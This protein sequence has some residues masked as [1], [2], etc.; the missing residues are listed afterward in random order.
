MMNSTTGSSP[1][2]RVSRRRSRIALALTAGWAL[3]LTPAP[4]ASARLDIGKDIEKGLG[5]VVAA[6]IEST[7]GVVDDP[8]LT[9]W[10]N[11]LGQHL[12]AVSGRTD[13]KYS[14][15]VLDSDE[16]NAT[17]APGGYIFVDRG[18][19]RFIQS[20]D[21]L[22]AVM[23][24]EVGHVAGR[25]AM[26]QLN[27]Q[28]LGTLALLGFQAVH[29]ETLKTVGG[30]AG[31]LAMLKYTRDQENDADRRGLRNATATGYD[32]SAMLTFFQRLETTEKEKPSKLEVYFLTHPPTAERIRRISHEPGAADTAANE[33]AIGDGCAQRSLFRSAVAAYRRSLKADPGNSAVKQRLADAFLQ[34][35]QP[36]QI[37]RLSP[38]DRDARLKQLAEFGDDLASAHQT[39]DADLKKLTDSQKDFDSELE[40]AARSL[41]TVSNVVN[42][43]D[44]LRFREFISMAGSFDQATR[45]GG[46]LRAA[47]DSAEETFRELE[48]LRASLHHAVESGDGSAALQV[49]GLTM[50]SQTML[51]DLAEGLKSARSESHGAREAAKSLHTAA[52]SLLATYRSPLSLTGGQYNILDLQVS[53]AQDSLKDTVAS[54]RKALAKVSQATMDVAVRRLNFLTRSLPRNDEATAG[55]AAHYLGAE[56]AQVSAMWQKLEL[57][58]AAL[59]V[60][61]DQIIKYWT[62]K[63]RSDKDGKESNKPI[64]FKNPKT[65]IQPENASVLFNLMARD[66]E[67]EVS[68]Q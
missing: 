10:V 21:E 56:P 32:G 33:A 37:P 5:K 52:D 59:A 60:A 36:T 58:D 2:F 35:P 31:G 43:R 48:A 49:E 41:S 4:P 62:E 24:H 20:E 27:A 61:Q 18:T 25:H 17:A 39:A 63:N 44:S 38:A 42:R 57:G 30:L 67:R 55:I 23:G 3:S 51:K 34:I 8:L 64:D 68:P 26:K 15:K 46:L 13:V 45:A 14:F 12:A 7:Y 40:L 50:T 9:G 22:A 28:L 16:V 19:L 54:S 47:R 66:L 1:Q 53:T 29:A 65:R 6:E 11:R